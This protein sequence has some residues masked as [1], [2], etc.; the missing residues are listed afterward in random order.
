MRASLPVLS[1]AGR[2][3][4]MGPSVG[5]HGRLLVFDSEEEWLL[6][7]IEVLQTQRKET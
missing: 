3:S 4:E 2:S 6:S 7:K 5:I 1:G